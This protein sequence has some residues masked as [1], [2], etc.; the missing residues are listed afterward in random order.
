[1]ADQNK[2]RRSSDDDLMADL[3]GDVVEQM[4]EPCPGCGTPLKRGAE[5]CTNC[6][7]RTESG[8]QMRTAVIKAPKEKQPK[9]ESSGGGDGIGPHLP[10]IGLAVVLGG[11]LLGGTQGIAATLLGWY[12]V[13]VIASFAAWIYLVY[14]AFK[15]GHTGWAIVALIPL[16]NAVSLIYVFFI[17]D[18]ASLKSLYGVL[19]VSSIAF[20]V[21]LFNGGF[22]S[23]LEDLAEQSTTTQTTR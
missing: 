5:L 11:L 22:D 8:K 6:G 12:I 17:S 3:L 9:G 13:T 23:I 15:D 16:I 2:K 10:A 1:M 19:F 7:Y 21:L 14:S 4:G 20:Y 18:R